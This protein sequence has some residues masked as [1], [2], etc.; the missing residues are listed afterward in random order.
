MISDGPDNK[1]KSLIFCLHSLK[2]VAK[3]RNLYCESLRSDSP[4]N[5]PQTKT[6]QRIKKQNQKQ[7]M[8][9][10]KVRLKLWLAEKCLL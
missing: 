10:S 9:L 3:T 1:G 5:I 4:G 6:P 7:Q 8:N 2:A